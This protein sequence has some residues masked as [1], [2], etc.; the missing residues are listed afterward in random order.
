MLPR[1][2]EAKP[3]LAARCLE[4]L[5]SHLNASSERICTHLSRKRGRI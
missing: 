4:A 5:A 1:I 2:R 3:V